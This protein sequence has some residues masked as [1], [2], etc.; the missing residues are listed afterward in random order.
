MEI[1]ISSEYIT[2]NSHLDILKFFQS[3]N[4]SVQVFNTGSTVKYNKKYKIENGLL[5]KLFDLSTD[6]FKNIVWPY[7]KD[8]YKLNCAYVKYTD[9][10]MGCILNWPNVF[11]KSNCQICE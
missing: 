10:Y 1:N 6:D 9:K 7:L 2:N 4:I 5:I 8:K 11:T 3:N